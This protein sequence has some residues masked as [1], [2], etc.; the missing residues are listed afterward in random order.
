MLGAATHSRRGVL[1][2]AAGR[3]PA[4]RPTGRPISSVSRSGRTQRR[5][6]SRTSLE[7]RRPME[8]ASG[9]GAVLVLSA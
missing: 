5:A 3:V 6:G 8:Q 4:C 9:R 1:L 2:T 7:R